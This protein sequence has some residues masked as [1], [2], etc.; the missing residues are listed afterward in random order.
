MRRHEA[1]LEYPSPIIP[2]HAAPRSSWLAFIDIRLHTMQAGD[3][4]F[5]VGGSSAS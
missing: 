2:A 5:C 4:A 1:V 3:R